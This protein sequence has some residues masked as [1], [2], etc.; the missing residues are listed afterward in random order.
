MKLSVCEQEEEEKNKKKRTKKRPGRKRRRRK[1]KKTFSACSILVVSVLMPVFFILPPFLLV[2]LSLCSC[3]FSCLLISLLSE[4]ATEL[5]RWRA[6]VDALP[7]GGLPRR[8]SHGLARAFVQGILVSLSIDFSYLAL[9]FWG[10][11]GAT[12]AV[13]AASGGELG[14]LSQGRSR[15]AVLAQH[16]Q[17]GT[18]CFIKEGGGGGEKKNKE[19]REKERWKTKEEEEEKKMKM[20]M[21]TMNEE[22]ERQL[23]NACCS[24]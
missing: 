10:L 20:M 22:L 19:K 23:Q 6:I 15:P 5:H 16:H 3:L 12:R 11:P 14:R 17:Q 9:T 4:P 24:K 2:F 21:M 1:K 13:L 18:A 8:C 7:A